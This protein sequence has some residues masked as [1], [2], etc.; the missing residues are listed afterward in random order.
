[1]AAYKRFPVDLPR[2]STLVWTISRTTDGFRVSCNDIEVLDLALSDEVCD[3]VPDDNY[4]GW[5]Q[6]YAR[7]IASVT[8]KRTRDAAKAFQTSSFY[9]HYIIF[10]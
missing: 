4:I 2:N 1:M 10:L 5:K 7:E 3:R 9:C 6:S 8:F